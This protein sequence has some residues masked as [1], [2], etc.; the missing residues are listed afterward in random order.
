MTTHIDAELDGSLDFTFDEKLGEVIHRIL[1]RRGVSQTEF[2]ENVLGI[3]QSAL[4]NKL[5][6]KRPFMAAELAKIADALEVD[7]NTL[8]PRGFS[9][10]FA[11]I[12]TR[13]RKYLTFE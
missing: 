13:D 6:G 1:W 8:T 11:P 5:R 7:L 2:A 12:G 3:T 4:S 9:G 10:P